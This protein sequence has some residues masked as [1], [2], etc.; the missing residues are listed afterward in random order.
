LLLAST[1]Y[2]VFV[3]YRLPWTTCCTASPGSTPSSSGTGSTR[4]SSARQIHFQKRRVLGFFGFF[5]IFFG[6][7]GFFGDFFGFLG[8]F[9]FFEFFVGIF[10]YFIQHCFICRPSRSTVSE[11]AGIEA[12]RLDLI[13]LLARS[14][15]HPLIG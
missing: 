5:W 10:E 2:V 6:F 15:S 9:G 7:F 3:Y 4:R 8:F 1:K 11:V 13:N 12:N 14:H